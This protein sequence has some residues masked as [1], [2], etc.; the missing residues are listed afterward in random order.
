VPVQCK[1]SLGTIFAKGAK[2]RLDVPTVATSV[3]LHRLVVFKAFVTLWAQNSGT[4][5]K[6]KK[7]NVEESAQEG[8]ERERKQTARKEG[9]FKNTATA[10]QNDAVDFCQM[11]AQVDLLICLVNTVVT[12]EERILAA[13]VLDVSVQCSLRLVALS[14][15]SAIERT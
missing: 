11:L 12:L 15:V 10:L 4:L 3:G 1:L 14:A 8:E 13:V 7:N 2:I 5:C 6:K 9:L